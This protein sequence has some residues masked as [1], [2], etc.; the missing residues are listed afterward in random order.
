MKV[1]ILILAFF[2][3]LSF[4]FFWLSL[5]NGF[6]H[7]FDFV[8]LRNS[9]EMRSDLSVALSSEYPYKF[10]PLVYLVH[11][12]LFRQF[13]F[14]P[15][16]YFIFN[17]ILHAI[18]A[19]LVY[20][21]VNTLLKDRTVSIVSGLLFVFTVGNYGK[22]VMIASGFE[23]LMITTLTLLTM[24]F[25]FKNELQRGGRL[26]TP[27]FFL[28]LIFFIASMFTKSTSFSILGCFIAFNFFFHSKE[29]RAK[30]SLFDPGFIILFAIVIAAI[31]TKALFFHY[32]PELYKHHPG[33]FRFVYYA[34]KN[35]VNYL[36]RM[37]FP[38]HTSHLVA[39]S[40]ALVVLIYKL[41]TE[42]RILIA[43][44]V[45]SYSFFGFVFG[46][47]TIRFFIAWTYIM[48]IPFA[49]FQFPNDWLNIRHLYLVSVGFVMVISAGAVYCSRLISHRKIRRFIPFLVPLAFVV[50]SRFIVYQLNKSYEYKIV[51]PS[52]IEYKESLA[53]RFPDVT[54]RDGRLQLED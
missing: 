45:F 52:V 35:V 22:A 17:I 13:G 39:N 9:L 46:N 11:Y 26:L 54:V 49:F 53:R 47:R 34:G 20:L 4:L 10:Q 27:Y 6:W 44:T 37:I 16:G 18:N 50:M 15:R 3:L 7:G 42:I 38:I 23:D 40:G 28:A 33:F 12:T 31:I 24:F 48:V 1:N 41:A 25:Y 30:K 43:L 8:N 19:F 5:D 2:L 29:E 51:E 32:T 21:L 36:V 14:D